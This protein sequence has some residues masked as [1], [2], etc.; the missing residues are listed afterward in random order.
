MGITSPAKVSTGSHGNSLSDP[1]INYGYALVDKDTNE[2]LKFGETLYPDTRYSKNY[3]EQNNAVMKV[4]ESGSKDYIHDWQH[5][6]NMY[7]KDKYG[8]FPTL[9]K[10]GW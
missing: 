3:L 10:G 5:T 1:R 4:L 6:M 2:I 8:N 9:N 7:F